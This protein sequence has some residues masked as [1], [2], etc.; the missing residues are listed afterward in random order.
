MRTKRRD[1]DYEAVMQNHC[2]YEVAGRG[3]GKE[4]GTGDAR[5]CRCV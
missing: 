4:L 2:D 3:C 5:Y 1:A